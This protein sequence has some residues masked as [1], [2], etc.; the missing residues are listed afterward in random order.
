MSTRYVLYGILSTALKAQLQAALKTLLKERW[1][2]KVTD[3]HGSVELPAST[4]LVGGLEA[5]YVFC[6]PTAWETLYELTPPGDRTKMHRSIAEYYENMTADDPHLF[7]CI[8][9]HFSH[10]DEGRALEYS[11]RA[12]LFYLNSDEQDLQHA[13]ALLEAS[14]HYVSSLADLQVLQVLLGVAELVFYSDVDNIIIKRA[15]G[16][17]VRSPSET[18]Q[19]A[20]R[21]ARA[22]GSNKSSGWGGGCCVWEA[23]AAIRTNK[24]APESSM[25]SRSSGVSGRLSYGQ[26]N[27]KLLR[28]D[29]SRNSVNAFTAQGGFPMFYLCYLCCSHQLT[30][31]WLC[32]P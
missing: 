19:A 30:V 28:Q 31:Y 14:C 6:H 26:K 11:C 25:L 7:E 2:M 21:S 23:A 13:L 22:G 18:Q 16:S 20:T 3:L 12:T 24:V 27:T 4:G 15:D 32:V 29:L 1:I 5:E 9:A 17:L 8:S 10:V